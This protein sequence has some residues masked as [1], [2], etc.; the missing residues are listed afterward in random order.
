MDKMTSQ[1]DR[2]TYAR[3]MGHTQEGCKANKSRKGESVKP[4][5]ITT[6]KGKE[7]EPPATATE[8]QTRTSEIGTNKGNQLEW[9]EW[10]KKKERNAKGNTKDTNASLEIADPTQITKSSS[11]QS[12]GTPIQHLTPKVGGTTIGHSSRGHAEESEG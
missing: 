9:V 5:D 8:G 12:Q 6:K 4:A 11:K 1:K 2:V 7:T 3:I 10:A